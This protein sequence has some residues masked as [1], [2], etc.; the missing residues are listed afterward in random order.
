[1][2]HTGM[3]LVYSDK[4]QE[5]N[6]GKCSLHGVTI[7]RTAFICTETGAFTGSQN[8]TSLVCKHNSET[9]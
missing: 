1:M 8:V 9:V 7:L 4:Y 3:L 6:E 2:H 5:E